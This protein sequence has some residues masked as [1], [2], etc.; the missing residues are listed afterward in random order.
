MLVD[1]RSVGQGTNISQRKQVN[2]YYP[3]EAYQQ[4][5]RGYQIEGE[6]R[7]RLQT[8]NTPNMHGHNLKSESSEIT[9]SVRAEELQARPRFVLPPRNDVD[10]V[11]RVV[12]HKK[13]T[14]VLTRMQKGILLRER[15]ATKREVAG[16]MVSKSKFCRKT[17]EDKI[18]EDGDDLLSEDDTRENRTLI[19][20]WVNF[21]YR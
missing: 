19:F 1:L 3:G 11:W 2:T 14:K 4:M 10:D 17:T 12:R 18:S 15:A 9:Q 16:K 8:V 21:T 6:N 7:S 20:V 5:S 13:F